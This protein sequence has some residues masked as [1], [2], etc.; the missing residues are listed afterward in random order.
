MDITTLESLGPALEEFCSRF[1]DCI[2]TRPSRRHLRT[3]LAGQL[4]PLDRKSVEPI[5]LA[6]GVPPRSL[7]EF[8]S[9][10]KWDE[11]KVARRVRELVVERHA[12]SRAVGVFDETSFAKKG[13]HTCGV[14]RQYCGES[15]KIDNCVVT[16]HL[17]Y[18]TDDF[19]CLVD[20]DV[21]LPEDAWAADPA[22]REEVGVPETVVHRPK[23]RIAL[24]LLDRC[25]ADGVAFPFM[26]ADEGYGRCGEFRA[27]LARRGLSYVVEV[28]RDTTGR[29]AG[30]P[31]ARRVDDLWRRGGPSW[32]AYHVKDTAHGPVVWEARRVRFTPAGETESV[33]LLVARSVLTG[34]TKWFMSNLTEDAAVEEMLRVAFMRWRVERCFQEAKGEIGLGHFEVRKWKS[35]RR[36][37]ILSCAALM[38]LNER[39][40]RL[41]GEKP[42]VDRVP[43]EGGGGGATRSWHAA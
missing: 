14:Q 4:G 5:A 35:L 27:G 33:W 42:V 21:F 18:A 7:Q 28:P 30:R 15:G 13:S 16:V 26:T 1:D 6:A 37:L 10:H 3:Y 11:E 31:E 34:E 40:A 41:R 29:I 19:H 36:H 9:L 2:K 32:E 43:G 8:L 39:T 17:A 25:L 24:E 23:W 20:S 22:R 38:F 12:D